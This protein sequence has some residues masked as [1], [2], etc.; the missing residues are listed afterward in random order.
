MNKEKHTISGRLLEVDFYPC[1]NSGREIPERE[2]KNQ[3]S[4]EQQALYNQKTATKKLVR[5]VNANFDTGDIYLHATYSPENA[6]QTSDK[7]YRDVYN[8]IRRIRY[9]RKKHKLPELRVVAIL[10]EK[11]YKTGKYAGLVNIHV[12]MFMNDDGFTRDRAEDFW[13]FGWVNARRY[14]PD[15]FG[16]ETAA[17]YVSKDPKGKKR[18]YCSQNLKKPVEREKKGKISNRYIERLAKRKDDRT[19]WENKYK[20]YA[21]ERVDARFNEYNQKW[22]VTAIMFKRS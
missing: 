19:F 10:E 8:Y 20:G 1:F 9:Y 11:T 18:W 5:L 14:N 22:Y 15:V 12:H 4:K 2:P 7:A 16:P 3:R 21:Y 6:P 13:K 17:R